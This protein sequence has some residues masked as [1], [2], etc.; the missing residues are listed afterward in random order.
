[1]SYLLARQERSGALWSASG[2]RAVDLVHLLAQL[3]GK[4]KGSGEDLMDGLLAQLWDE[5]VGG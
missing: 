3:V 5:P 1:M 2:L 4:R